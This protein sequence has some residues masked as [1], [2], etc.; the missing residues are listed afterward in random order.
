MVAVV[1]SSNKHRDEQPLCSVCIANYNGEE[2]LADCIDSILTQKDFPGSVEII[3]HDD[4]S[5]DGSVAFLQSVYPQVRLLTSAK[6]VGFCISNNRMVDVAEG[7]YILL[8]NNDAVLHKDVLKTFYS[9]SQKYGEGI[10]GLPQY[11]AENGELIDV[12]SIFD[13]FLNPVPNK[14]TDKKDVGMIIGACLW[15]SKI[16]WDKLGG[17]PD[18]FG[19]L[20][21][22]M[23]ICCLARLWGYPVKALPESGFDHW[24]GKSLGGGKVLND[25][26]LSTTLSRRGLSERNKT[27]VMIISY[28][29]SVAF[30]LVPLHIFLLLVEGSLLSILKFNSRVWKE[31]YWNC[32]QQVWRSRKMLMKKR[33]EV[34]KTRQCPTTKFFQV[35]TIFPYKISMLVKHG[36]PKISS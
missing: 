19:S 24:V 8:L 31:I 7:M 36:L 1:N 14:D 4:A 32:V 33:T 12:G 20:A 35:F 15:I 23:Y 22:D 6:N 21:E 27:F 34:Q 26:S 5:T 30:F 10:L 9:G 29:V 25:G 28:P 11:N 18:W 16:L 2:Y 3:V 13:P 17:F